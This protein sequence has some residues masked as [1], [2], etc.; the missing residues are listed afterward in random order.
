MS[1][2]TP[3][4]SRLLADLDPAS[5]GS[6]PILLDTAGDRAYFSLAEGPDPEVW[7]SDGDPET[8]LPAT[9]LAARGCTTPSPD[10]A[11]VASGLLFMLTDCGVGL[12][13]WATA[14][15]PAGMVRLTRAD[16]DDALERR[17]APWLPGASGRCSR[18]VATASR[19]GNPT[20]HRR[21]LGSSWPW[22]RRSR[23]S[24]T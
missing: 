14:G 10:G 12:E 13:L 7:R 5:D 24:A 4:T 18:R 3:V 2:G 20:A 16:G 6:R 23:A 17:S 9:D 8:T 19:C 11:R 21:A 1:Q 15:S 22:T